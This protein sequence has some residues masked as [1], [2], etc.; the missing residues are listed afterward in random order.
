MASDS[1]CGTYRFVLPLRAMI[2]RSWCSGV[3]YNLHAAFEFTPGS[4]I[5][6]QRH[7]SLQGDMVQMIHRHGS[8]IVHDIDDLLWDIPADNPNVHALTPTMLDEMFRSMRSV[9]CVTTTTKPL[10]AAL[11]KR[12]IPAAVVPN[13][14]DPADWKQAPRSTE[15]SRLR[16]G[17]YG[18]RNVHIDDLN[19]IESVVRSLR[20]EVDFVF[21]GDLPHSLAADRNQFEVHAPNAIELFPATLAALDLDILLS[22]LAK[23]AFN[24]CKSNLRLLQAGMLG[25]AVIA[26]DIEPHRTLPVTLVSN[27]PADWERALR[28]R[29][30]EIEAVRAEGRYL[31]ASVREDYTLDDRRL[32]RIFELWTQRQPN[33]SA[34]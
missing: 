7:V 19:I 3:I 24:E 11:A 14:L 34:A 26:T 25:I 6:I 5:L 31:E 1:I 2:A 30:G 23:N 8:R 20:N 29:I 33:V 28:E 12:G 9:D 27:K 22:P 16:V 10:A 17:W 18:Q 15:R 4:T 32:A 13:L 21:Y